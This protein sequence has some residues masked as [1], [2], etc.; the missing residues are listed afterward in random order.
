MNNQFIEEYKQVLI[1]NDIKYNN[2]IS[3]YL[4]ANLGKHPGKLSDLEYCFV[5]IGI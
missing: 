3:K 2:G 4:N 5:I 1:Q